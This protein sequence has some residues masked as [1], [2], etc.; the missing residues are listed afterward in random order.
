[1][2]GNILVLKGRSLYNVLRTAA[3]EMI[4]AF[5]E[6]G[7]QVTIIDITIE[8]D[9]DRF[10]SII[11]EKFKLIFSFQ[12]LMFEFCLEDGRTSIFNLCKD[13]PV[14]GHIVDHPIYLSARATTIHGDNMYVGCVD[15]SHVD[16]INKYYPSVKNA[17]FLPH[18]G[19]IP[20]RVVPYEQRR[21]ELYFPGSYRRPS[22]VQNKIEELPEVYRNMANCLISRMI[23]NPL[24]ALQD[25]LYT[26]LNQI[27]FDYS[28]EEF[29]ELMNL[30]SVVDEFIH[31]S[32]RDRCIRGLVENGISITVSGSGWDDIDADLAAQ[33]TILSSKGVDFL[34][35]LELMAD[36]KLVLNHVP[37]LQKGMHERI[38]TSMICG[39]VCLTHDFPI[40]HEE[41]C[42][43]ENVVLYTDSEL[44]L[45]AEKIKTLLKTPEKAKQIAMKG[46]EIAKQSHTWAKNAQTVLKMV[47]LETEID[48]L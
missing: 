16:Y 36:S 21:I 48:T 33:I 26:Y 17:V 10:L 46:Q 31:E 1:M 38:F 41:F 34:D 13:T 5:Q 7:Y 25:A 20:K 4:E 6:Q 12:A 47:G 27:K 32:S 8:E 14:F 23:E 11:Q 18:G 43:G 40:M 24:L 35:V 22:N 15:R 37:T 39:A 28:S 9:A 45:F 29:T 19:F 42:D 30:M 2:K 44:S 3:D